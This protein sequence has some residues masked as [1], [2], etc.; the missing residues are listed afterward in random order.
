MDNH[1]VSAHLKNTQFR[2]QEARQLL[3]L[4]KDKYGS[5]EV[6]QSIDK[7]LALLSNPLLNILP[8]AGLV[9]SLKGRPFSLY[10][11]F[12]FE[13]LFNSYLTQYTL[14]KCGRQTG[15]T[16]MMA[17]RMILMGR[18]IPHF[19]ILCVAPLFSIIRRISA[20]YV[21][22][23]IM[24]SPIRNLL[25]DPHSSNNVLQRSFVNGST[26]F[27][28]YAYRDVERTRGFP[29]DALFRDEIQDF[30]PSFLPIIEETLSA[31]L[32]SLIFD[33][34]TPKSLNN[35][36]EYQ[37]TNSSRAEWV[38]PCRRCRYENVP[39][40]G[41]DL[42][43]MFGPWREDI[44]EE[45]PAVICA[46]CRQVIF[47]RDGFWL[48]AFPERR[49]TR[50]GYHVPQI[51]MP[52]HYAYP[53]KWSRILY[54]RDN[55]APATF[56][57]EVCAESYDVGT[58]LLTLTDILNASVLWDNDLQEAARHLSEY[59]LIMLG[60]DWGGG[61]EENISYT[62]YAVVGYH[63]QGTIDVLFGA[64]SNRPHDHVWEAKFALHLAQQL[65]C[66]AIVHD[67]A[68]AGFFREKYMLDAGWPADRMI[69]VMYIRSPTG[70]LMRHHAPQQH[71]GRS[72]YQLD[73]PKSLLLLCHEIKN[74]RV[75]FFKRR[76]Q[77]APS[78][79]QSPDLTD[80]FLAL[81]EE[82]HE[83]ASGLTSYTI[84]RKAGQSDDF[85]HAVN[86]AACAIWY[87]LQKWPRAAYD[88]SV[89]ETVSIRENV[90]ASHSP[91][92]FSDV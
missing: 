82:K 26:I 51:I 69:P 44:S 8:L 32:W 66:W 42:D 87:S 13:P 40:L 86:M 52:F 46:K 33:A 17:A 72:Y 34:G 61:G 85:A 9:L 90:P 18:F 35:Y 70:V 73:K 50:A 31:S 25:V 88:I 37:W 19:N 7:L 77:Y 6:S 10:N 76:Q 58:R 3:H 48:H 2:R 49:P 41:Y 27:F 20:K 39:A 28:S 81:V 80:D 79:E 91:E 75:R 53:D 29:A 4:I 43:E 15:K 45:K 89:S 38:I 11:H 54:K 22:T 64:S 47:P 1:P 59:T 23:F 30:E 16:T 83:T 62:K 24:E 68:G 56:Y 55:L 60:I 92:D 63:L 12:V 14:L 84:V 21:R 67:Y 5:P 78:M 71:E 36:L 74:R 65:H 57:N